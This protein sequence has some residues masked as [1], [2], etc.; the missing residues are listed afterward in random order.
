MSWVLRM[1]NVMTMTGA[2]AA[3]SVHAAD[4]ARNDFR[5]A[6][7]DG[8]G[9]RVRELRPSD[10]R[11]GEPLILVHGARV[12]GLASFDLD[13]PGGSLAADLAAR[14]RRPV[15]VLDARGYG[16]SDR[17]AAMLRPARESR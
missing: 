3:G 6:T 17:W 14:L 8:V 1:L 13:V 15:L 4:L 2:L 7:A 12:P 10:A 16:G 11:V 9:I 5:V